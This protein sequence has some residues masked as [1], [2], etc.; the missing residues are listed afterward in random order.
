MG[1]VFVNDSMVNYYTHQ[2]IRNIIKEIW[3]ERVFWIREFTRA[4]ADKSK[5][6]N[7]IREKLYK[8]SKEFSNV[9]RNIYSNDAGDS[10]EQIL[11]EYIDIINDYI[12][13]LQ[14]G[15]TEA[16]KEI[17]QRFDKNSELFSTVLNL[18]NPYYDKRM[19]A[20]LRFEFVRFT[21]EMILKHKNE[22][23]EEE[24]NM[25]ELMKSNILTMVDILSEGAILQLNKKHNG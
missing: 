24:I 6:V 18:L 3:I 1:G 8:N 16:I 25:F 15:N 17:E 13:S 20:E 21:K 4:K 23:Y 9:L 2:Q 19:I 22:Q 11:N 12:D 7:N 10:L 5:D 14:S